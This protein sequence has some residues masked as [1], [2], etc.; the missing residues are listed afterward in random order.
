MYIY[1][2][3]YEY[4]YIYKNVKL[5]IHISIYISRVCVRERE[6]RERDAPGQAM[7]GRA[8]PRAPARPPPETNG[9]RTTKVIQ[10]H[11][12]YTRLL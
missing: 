2:Y 5:D 8:P 1:I 4:I 11:F 9:V 10:N 6:K 7:Q 12:S 3:V